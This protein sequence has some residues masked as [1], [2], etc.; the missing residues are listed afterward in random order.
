MN[1]S[2]LRALGIAVAVC[3]SA[4]LVGCSRSQSDDSESVYLPVFPGSETPAAL[5]EGSLVREGRCLY[6]ENAG[7]RYLILWPPGVGFDEPNVVG[8][9]GETLA[10]IGDPILDAGGGLTSLSAA[11]DAVEGGV[12]ECQTDQVMIVTFD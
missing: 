5:I 2:S 7:K 3:C 8:G 10:T 9:S 12:Q 6:L 11:Q 1:A 4:A